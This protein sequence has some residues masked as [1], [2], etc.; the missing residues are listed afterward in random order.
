MADLHDLARLAAATAHG[1]ELDPALRYDL[2]WSAIAV[3]LTEAD[4]P[5]T[6]R[7]L[8]AAGRTDIHAELQ[9]VRHARGALSSGSE[10][11]SSRAYWRF[12]TDL[13]EERAED[14]LTDRIAV[15]QVLDVLDAQLLDVIA[16]LAVHDDYRAAANAL[17]MPYKLLAKKIGVA[18]RLVWA[19]WFAP[20]TAPARRGYDKRRGNRPPGDRCAAGHL[21]EGSNVRLRNRGRGRTSRVCRTCAAVRAARFTAGRAA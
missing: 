10:T 5:P 3:A 14:R 18:R 6:R 4:E 2:A 19:A 12:W 16:A 8:L 1:G 11:A 13:P 7:D 9:A 20:E 21:L 17:G 15:R